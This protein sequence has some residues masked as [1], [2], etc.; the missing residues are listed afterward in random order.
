MKKGQKGTTRFIATVSEREKKKVA[1]IARRL[2]KDGL[3]IAHVSTLFGIITGE[4]SVPLS[5]L[6][7]KYNTQGIRF[8]SDREVGI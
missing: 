1:S 6:Q 3:A 5:E 8:E 7:S 2:E 4:A